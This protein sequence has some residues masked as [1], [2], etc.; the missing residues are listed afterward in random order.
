MSTNTSLHTHFPSQRGT[1][2]D[3]GRSQGQECLLNQCPQPVE[4]HRLLHQGE[5]QVTAWGVAPVRDTS[6]TH[7]HRGLHQ[8]GPDQQPFPIPSA[9]SHHLSAYL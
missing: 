9:G 1:C 2:R 5:R 4:L 8:L 7:T 3:S 6:H